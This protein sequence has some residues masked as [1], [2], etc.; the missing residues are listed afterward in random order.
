MPIVVRVVTAADYAK[1]VGEKKKAMAALA[2]DPNK[3]WDIAELK[4]RG[5]KVYAANCQVC[6]QAGGTG[7]PNAFPPLVGSKVVLGPR[8]DQIDVVLNGRKGVFTSNS[9]MPPMGA[10]S[11]V[12]IAAVITYTRTAWGNAAAEAL[13]QPSEVKSLRK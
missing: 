5:E 1:W 7:V 9:L 6:H 4:A 10:L 3:V 2:D 11:D 13:V 8:A 12:E